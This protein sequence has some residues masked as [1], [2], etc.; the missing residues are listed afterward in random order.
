MPADHLPAANPAH[1][2]AEELRTARAQLLQIELAIGALIGR[3]PGRGPVAGAAAAAA[4][5]AALQQARA[6]AAYGAEELAHAIG[7]RSTEDAR[8]RAAHL[9]RVL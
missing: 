2:T 6:E 7:V 1:A 8:D 4:V 3:L 9:R 5:A